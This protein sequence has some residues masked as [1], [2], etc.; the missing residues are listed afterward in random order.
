MYTP[1]VPQDMR[2]PNTLEVEIYMPFWT[3]DKEGMEIWDF[4]GEAGK[5]QVDT[6][7]TMEQRRLEQNRFSHGSFFVHHTSNRLR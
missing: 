5:S 4:K 1:W 6:K 3:K 2:P 7:L